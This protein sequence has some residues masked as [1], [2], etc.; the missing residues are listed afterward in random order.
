MSIFMSKLEKKEWKIFK[1]NLEKKYKYDPVEAI[2][3]ARKTI[4]NVVETIRKKKLDISDKKGI[5]GLYNATNGTS[6][7]TSEILNI[8]ADGKSKT[9]KIIGIGT[10]WDR[11]IRNLFKKI[12]KIN[13]N[14]IDFIN[15]FNYK[16]YL[17]FDE[18]INEI[19]KIHD[20]SLDKIKKEKIIKKIEQHKDSQKINKFYN[21]KKNKK[22]NTSAVADPYRKY[23]ILVND[24]FE[25]IKSDP[26][27]A[28]DSWDKIQ[29]KLHNANQNF[30]KAKHGFSNIAPRMYEAAIDSLQAFLIAACYEKLKEDIK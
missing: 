7:D 9:N 14:F 22:F 18:T 27:D 15:F 11:K 26:Y 19:K 4:K 5:A 24:Y 30:K 29:A 6:K 25:K 28:L 20:K 8:L 17:T 21:D 13:K 12:I 16:G 3:Q 1:N 2:N 23:Y 10:A